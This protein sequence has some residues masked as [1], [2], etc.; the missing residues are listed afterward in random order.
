MVRRCIAVTLAA[1]VATAGLHVRADEKPKPVASKKARLPAAVKPDEERDAV[2][3]PV[4]V[5]V[6]SHKI[7]PPTP[8]VPP[9]APTPTLP[10]ALPAVAPT[11]NSRPATTATAASSPAAS[12]TRQSR[13]RRQKW[14][15]A[16]HAPAQLSAHDQP[17]ITLDE[18]LQEIRQQHKLPVRIDLANVLPLAASDGVLV[19]RMPS[20]SLKHVA[21]KRP[22]QAH[23]KHTAYKSL[24]AAE[25]EE[26]QE[27]AEQNSPTSLAATP[28]D[29]DGEVVLK[30][31]PEHAVDGDP[32]R[33]NEPAEMLQEMTQAVLTSKLP[34]ELLSQP[35][36]TVE[37]VLREAF[38][39]AFPLQF[40]MHAAIAEMVPLP[41]PLTRAAEWELLIQDDGVLLTTRLNAN[42]HK[43]TR[44]YS[45]KSLEK[46][47][48]MKADAVARV[49]TRTV[50]P[51]S[52]R[53]N[54]PDT[55]A[56]AIRTGS[57][58][59]KIRKLPPVNV[60][61][62]WLVSERRPAQGL[63]L[64]SD[65]ETATKDKGESEITAEDLALIGQLWDYLLQGSITA[66]QVIH[67][68]D[69][70]T[71]VI[72]VLP[73]TL[74]ITQSQG[75]HREIADLLDQLANKDQ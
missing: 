48:G 33:I 24:V 69:P 47:G 61:L 74:V 23:V 53:T 18:L 28:T 20:S 25:Y 30:A 66:L 41:A 75:A 9:I 60:D 52:W 54:F 49:I 13:L 43:E 5:R 35:E 65:E 27:N 1:F 44:V 59:L 72:E 32:P 64:V 16:L 36:S 12:I 62:S 4:S 34:A 58:P 3:E 15:D 29:T 38:N 14:E 2:E 57:A 70:P 37:D 10:L 63:R 19:R 46:S 71:G 55:A 68:G 39:V 40:Q 21:Q 11:L 51:W 45:I 22:P 6:R 31:E 42:M 56:P 50:R 67:H 8:V 73:G 17:V 26:E 7:Y